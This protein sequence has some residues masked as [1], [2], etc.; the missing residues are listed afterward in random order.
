MSAHS[1]SAAYDHYVQSGKIQND[2]AQREV[3]T[4]LQALSESFAE[5]RKNGSMLG[6]LFNKIPASASARSIYIWGSVG[7]GKSMLMDLFF[8]SV[9]MDRKRRVHFHAFM[10]E[11]HARIHDLRKEWARE[12]SG[13]D[14][15]IQL[16]RQIAEETSLL[17]FDELQATDVADATLLYRLF[18]ELF[19]SGVI[20]VSTSNRP[21]ESLYTGEIQK[22][23][24]VK[25]IALVR[26][27]MQV[28]S[29]ASP[30]D[31]RH[32]QLKSLTQMYYSPLGTAADQFIETTITAICTNPHPQHGAVMMH[33]R[34]VS[35]DLYD[36]M[37]GRFR[38]RDLCEAALGAG[39]Y[40]AITKR[41]DTMIL[42]DIP[43]IPPEKRNEAKRFV[44]LIDALYEHKVKLIC[45]AE[46][47]PDAIYSEGDGA[48]EFQ[49]TVSRLAEM[50]S[51][52]WIDNG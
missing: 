48:F 24:F 6:R 17:C 11:V 20:M 7:R 29:L 21:P 52:K 28:I 49:R 35:F 13:V 4:A 31:Y 23:R 30:R 19:T 41:L 2:S 25:F 38:F 22:E 39:D 33:G 32:M 43:R 34:K 47:A 26:E 50:Q 36:D 9:T 46:T 1:L 18:S 37:I 42:T 15:V 45:T 44:M 40:L 51:Q 14:P 12:K 27:H 10:Q 3:L 16:A 8:D 5:P